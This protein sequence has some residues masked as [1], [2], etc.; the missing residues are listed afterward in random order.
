MASVNTPHQTYI[1][2]PSESGKRLFLSL[3]FGLICFVGLF[4]NYPFCSL[5]DHLYPKLGVSLILWS[6]FG[7]CGFGV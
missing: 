4:E 1:P 5:H 2:L 7:F 6:H 3:S